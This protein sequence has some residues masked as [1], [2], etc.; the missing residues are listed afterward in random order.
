MIGV[1]TH[2]HVHV[3]AVMGTLGRVC[4]TLTIAT[5]AAGVRPLLAWLQGFRKIRSFGIEGTGSYGADLT[6]SLRRQD[7][8]VVEVSRSDRRLRQL[9][10]MAE[11]SNSLFM[12]ERIRNPRCT[13]GR[14][15]V[16][17]G[18]GDLG[19]G[20]PRLVERSAPASE[21]GLTPP[22][23]FEAAHCASHDPVSYIQEQIPIGAGSK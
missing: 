8:D 21:I 1:D 23:E 11:A 18:C 13:R 4:A 9:N 16:D 6:S 15:G 20:V 17:P 22:V 5:G 7:F 10:V 12:A 19:R 3:A 14:V 2:K